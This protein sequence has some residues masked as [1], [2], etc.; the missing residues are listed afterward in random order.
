M[1]M[2]AHNG[3]SV[4]TGILTFPML[5]DRLSHGITSLLQD[6]DRLAVIIEFVVQRDGSFS[7]G[8]V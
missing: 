6:K 3:T 1:N 2:Q 4:Y 8:E 7:P 5:P